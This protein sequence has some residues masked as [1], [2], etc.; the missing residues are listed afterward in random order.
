MLC[1]TGDSS[2]NLSQQLVVCQRRSNSLLQKQLYCWF[3]WILGLS[4][5]KC[6]I[7]QFW[8]LVYGFEIPA[9]R[10]YGGWKRNC[11]SLSFRKWYSSS[12]CLPW[13]ELVYHFSG[14]ARFALLPCLS[15][16]VAHSIA[17][18]VSSVAYICCYCIVWVCAR[19]QEL[20]QIALLCWLFTSSRSCCGSKDIFQG[21]SVLYYCAV[22]VSL[23]VTAIASSLYLWLHAVLCGL[24]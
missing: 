10:W 15:T 20:L 18:S 24:V 23:Y 7:H 17:W 4:V 8:F 1:D 12:M 9:W 3:K 19:M 14:G 11:D 13:E 6:E 22:L 21:R 5:F 2:K 16:S